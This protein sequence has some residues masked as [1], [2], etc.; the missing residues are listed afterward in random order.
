MNIYDPIG[1]ALG[2]KPSDMSEVYNLPYRKIATNWNAIPWNK[3]K[4][5]TA[6][7][8]PKE[9]GEAI[10][11]AK[12]GKPINTKGE[13]H[14]RSIPIYCVTTG[15]HFSSGG[16][17]IRKYP[18]MSRQNLSHHLK[19]KQKTIDGKVFIYSKSLPQSV[20]SFHPVYGDDPA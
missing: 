7:P 19:G 20:P 16:D 3:G 9:R 2:L 5:Y 6:G 8:Y 1:E 17:A 18:R 12:K 10:S 11:R 13:K 15:E 14:W 4:T